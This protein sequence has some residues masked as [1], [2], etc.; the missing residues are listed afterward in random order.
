MP[1]ARATAIHQALLLLGVVVI[2]A[3][4]L[5]PVHRAPWTSF[6]NE[7]CMGLGLAVLAL[8]RVPLRE[9]YEMPIAAWTI[10]MLAAIPWL[11]FLFGIVS[12]GGDAWIATLYLC[13]FSSAIAIGFQRPASEKNLAALLAGATLIAACVTSAIGIDQS[14]SG[15]IARGSL[16]QP[17][18]V[19]TLIAFGSIGLLLLRE[20]EYIGK[21][22]AGSLLALLVAG[23]AATQS[24]TALLYGPA[25]LCVLFVVGKF[26]TGPIR[27]RLSAVAIATVSHWA[28]AFS[29][30]FIKKWLA[31]SSGASLASRGLESSRFQAWNM[32]LA[33]S[34]DSPWSG[35][36]WLEAVEGQFNV[37]DRFPPFGE[38]YYQTHNLL[39]DLV[40][41]CGYPLALLLIAVLATWLATRSKKV[42]KLDPPNRMAPICGLLTV[43]VFLI[44]AML[45]LPHQ[46][47]Y[48]L[49][50]VGCW[51]G[52]IE[53]AVGSNPVGAPKI[54]A[55]TAIAAV[56]LMAAIVREYLFVERDVEIAR[57]QFEQGNTAPP[58]PPP[59]VSPLM[60]GLN[61]NTELLRTTPT[62]GLTDK[63]IETIAK[64]AKR[65][66]TVYNLM[67]YS[68]TLA[69]NGRLEESRKILNKILLI[70]GDA[71][72]QAIRRYLRALIEQQK[73]SPKDSRI[74]SGLQALEQSLPN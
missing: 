11:Q 29:L 9:P 69:V 73:D 71:R 42:L 65:Y 61:A 27:T 6:Y 17:N 58:N 46:Y 25:L 36:G 54:N 4:W 49:I 34:K 57:I 18:N 67:T 30:P 43:T 3:A 68:L 15:R 24:R 16:G 64:A 26:G 14:L 33:A 21:T 2:G 41:W 32:F 7:A 40:V 20:R 56:I 35:Y 10:L 74:A 52:V 45:E 63:E 38:L 62:A 39:L 66:P 72:Y 19:A 23:A 55:L 47:A 51:I 70:H 44:H 31:V 50:P 37:S 13:G 28:L 53:R 48:L 5:I 12:Y 60:S 59:H 1:T 22:L 8:S